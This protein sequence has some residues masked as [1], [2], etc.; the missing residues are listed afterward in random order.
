MSDDSMEKGIMGMMI[1]VMGVMLLSQ[2]VYGMQP[3]P[4]ETPY[5]C[6]VCGLQF[7][8]YDELY[9]HFTTEHPSE[10]IDIIWD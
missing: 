2:V 6:P 1:A 8:T 10:P 5:Q 7:A 9:T 3:Q 4:P